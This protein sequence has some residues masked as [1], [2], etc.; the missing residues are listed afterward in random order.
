M[1]TKENYR[2]ATKF[3]FPKFEPVFEGE[4]T[5]HHTVKRILGDTSGIENAGIVNLDINR[6]T[7]EFH[8]GG[9]KKVYTRQ[10]N[11]MHTKNM[12]S[13]IIILGNRIN[14]SILTVIE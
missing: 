10:G 3:E 6:A 2:P 8:P 14:N 11:T 4:G 7:I 5:L 13:N 1:A 9:Y 12:P